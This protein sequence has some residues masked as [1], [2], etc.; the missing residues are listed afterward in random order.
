MFSFKPD[1]EATRTRMEAF[2]ARDVLDRPILIASADSNPARPIQRRLELLDQPEAWFE[3]KLADMIYAI[4]ALG[5][6]ERT[7]CLSVLNAFYDFSKAK[8]QRSFRRAQT[9]RRAGTLRHERTISSS[10]V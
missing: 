1:F 7:A 10:P 3:A 9:S 8:T 6:A 5:P 2:W 4:S